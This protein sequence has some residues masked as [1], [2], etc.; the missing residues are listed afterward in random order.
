MTSAWLRLDSPSISLLLDPRVT[1]SFG[2]VTDRVCGLISFR[3]T[4]IFVIC[5]LITSPV[6]P[7]QGGGYLYSWK[8]TQRRVA[9]GLRGSIHMAL[10]AY[11]RERRHIITCPCAPCPY[12][13]A[14]Y[15]TTV[16]IER[17]RLCRLKAQTRVVV[18][19]GGQRPSGDRG[20][21]RQTQNRS[22]PNVLSSALHQLFHFITSHPE[23][24]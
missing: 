7:T 19:V 11:T 16:S 9:V 2:M 17:K 14:P 18:H 23:R 8:Q 4:I 15:H 13:R 22:E 6:R 21:R 5:T 10:C 3:G 12:C 1:M 20:K 24:R